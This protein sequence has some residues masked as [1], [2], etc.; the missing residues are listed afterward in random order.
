MLS[1]RR[2]IAL[3]L[4]PFLF[5]L[6]LI[7]Y[8]DRVNVSFAALRMS[9][10]LHFSDSVYGLGAGVFFLTYVLFEIPGAVLVE[11]W[12]ARKWIAR[13][14]VTWG[15]VTIFTAFVE[16]ATQFYVARLLLGAA[17]ASFYPGVIVYITRW[18]RLEDRAR[19]IAVFYAAIPAGAFVGSSIAGWLLGINWLNFAGWRWL[20]IVE[21][22]PAVL[23]GIVTVFFLTDHP[24]QASWLS[25]SERD[26]IVSEIASERAAQKN[27]YDMTFW[28]ACRDSRILLIA[29]GYF[30]FQLAGIS[31]SFWLPT[32]LK[33]LSGLPAPSVARLLMIPA[34]VGLL[35][36]LANAWH[37]D[38]TG[39]RKW[40]TV[41][42]VACAGIVY[43]SAVPAHTHFPLVVLFVTLAFSFNL[44]S[45]PGIW[46]MPTTI[47]SGTT[48][49]ATAFAL[50]T[51]VSQIG[52]FVGP[53][54]VG[55]LNDRTHSILPSIAAIGSSYLVA[56]LIFFFVSVESSPAHNTATLVPTREATNTSAQ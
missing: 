4:L 41:I 39:E 33:R 48:A 35:P 37:S 51:S 19:A 32:F 29:A 13:I 7:N 24:S 53:Y 26:W 50:I 21:G 30:F 45:V 36:L 3:R 49:A 47:L 10:D 18:F 56:A 9:A 8:V 34:V 38:R 43:L 14:M 5:T 54:L 25:T 40:H 44:A 31:S 52:A 55:Y 23:A 22:I 12:S 2:R 46:A 42:P 11:R 6:Y 28:Q 16:N 1:A 27:K 15:L 20:F 17:E